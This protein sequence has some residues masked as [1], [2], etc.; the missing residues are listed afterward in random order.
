MTGPRAFYSGDIL[1]STVPQA[2]WRRWELFWLEPG[3][4]GGE[5]RAGDSLAMG[6]RDVP[7][8]GLR[9]AGFLLPGPLRTSPWAESRPPASLA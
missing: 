4:W 5:E 6:L 8:E 3:R 9:R 7:F 1:K 2:C